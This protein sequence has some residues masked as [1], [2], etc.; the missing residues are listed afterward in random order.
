[1]LATYCNHLKLDFNKTKKKLLQ[2]ISGTWIIHKL[3][4]RQHRRC[5]QQFLWNFEESISVCSWNITFTGLE[6]TESNWFSSLVLHSFISFGWNLSHCFVYAPL[7]L[8]WYPL[9][10]LNYWSHLLCPLFGSSKT[11]KGASDHQ[12]SSRNKKKK[13]KRWPCAICIM[14]LVNSVSWEHIFAGY[15]GTVPL[16]SSMWHHQYDDL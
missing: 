15:C 4:H 14:F 5:S 13:K 2:R 7:L 3:W 12:K 11:T 1:M 16:F 6:E 9:Y 10:I 8:H